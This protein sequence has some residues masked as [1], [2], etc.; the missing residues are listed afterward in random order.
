[1]HPN[2]KWPVAV[3]QRIESPPEKVWETIS[4]PGNLE[5]CHPFCMRN[6]VE[7]WPGG[8]SRDEV[9]YLN[10]RIYK[11]RFRKWLP[12]VGYDL[13]IGASGAA[14]SFVS[15]RIQP[16]DHNESVLRITVYPYLLQTV[17][18]LIRWLPHKLYVA[19]M[20]SK[21]LSSVTKGFQWYLT[22]G[23]PVPRNQFGSHPW[24]SSPPSAKKPTRS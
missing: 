10:G 2:F 16:A 6:P 21:Y 1:M 8:D 15:W 18:A 3:A 17:P 12:G 4:T 7:K 23:K 5:L 24:F 14:P 13:E 20:L 22:H 19:P 9:H 11:R